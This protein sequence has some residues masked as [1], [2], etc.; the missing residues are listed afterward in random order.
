MSTTLIAPE[1]TSDPMQTAGPTT[2]QRPTDANGNPIYRVPEVNLTALLAKV[3]KLNRRAR[4]LGMIPIVVSEIGEEFVTERRRIADDFG[5]VPEVH[6]VTI[7]FVTLTVV[8]QTPRVD[9]WEFAA[10]IQHEDGGNIL[11]TCPGFETSLPLDY[12]QAET[13]CDHCAKDRRRNDTYILFNPE[14]A[15]WKQVGRSCLGD[16]LRTTN[17]QSLAEWA[18]VIAALDSEVSLYEDESFDTDGERRK[19]YFGVHTLLAQVRC[20]VRQDGWCSRGE[21]RNSFVPK[22]ATVDQAFLWFDPKF[23]GQQT[24]DARTKYAPTPEDS[25]EAAAAIVW[26]QNLPAD[27]GN[28]YLWNIRVVAHKEYVDVRAAGLAGSIIVAYG[29][30]LE[31]EI[32][33]KYESQHPSEYFGTPKTRETFRLTVVGMQERDGDFGL[34]T[35]VKFKLEGTNN[36]GLW[37]A[38]GKPAFDLELGETYALVATV[39]K[40]ELYRGEHKQTVVTRVAPFVEKPKKPRKRKTTPA[41]VAEVVQ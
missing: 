39:K 32:A 22:I 6:E 18:E 14:T 12:R 23:V 25:A 9:G 33:R 35:M 10:T 41:D 30:H 24:T 19:A 21:A 2:Q 5:G 20:I 37:W 4:R 26:A 29:R 38:S 1:F 11:R 34:T 17:P 8:G 3:D 7:R 27:V 28:D 13:H 15:A 16:F 31:R 40:H 36:T